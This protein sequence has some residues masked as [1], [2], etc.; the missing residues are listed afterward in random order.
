MLWRSYSGAENP[1]VCAENPGAFDDNPGV[2]VESPGAFEGNGVCV[3]NLGV[4][5][6][7]PSR[8]VEHPGA[9]LWKI[10]ALV[11]ESEEDTYNHSAQLIFLFFF[12]GRKRLELLPKISEESTKKGRNWRR[13]LTRCGRYQD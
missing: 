7:N 3:F 8:L 5:V 4:F 9:F 2:C 11:R 1:G 12:S 13:C 10:R 6:Q